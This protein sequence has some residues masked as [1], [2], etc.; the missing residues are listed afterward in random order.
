M[1]GGECV[2]SD[3][4]RKKEGGGMVDQIF[5]REAI[6]LSPPG[7]DRLRELCRFILTSHNQALH[8]LQNHAAYEEALP[9]LGQT[10]KLCRQFLAEVSTL[11][12]INEE[13]VGSWMEEC[14]VRTY[15]SCPGEETERKIMSYD[16]EEPPFLLHFFVELPTSQILASPMNSGT[17]VNMTIIVTWNWALAHHLMGILMLNPPLTTHSSNPGCLHPPSFYFQK[18]TICYQLAYRMLQT[19]PSTRTVT[20][21]WSQALLNNLALVRTQLGD[22]DGADATWEC[23]WRT[24]RAYSE[25]DDNHSSSHAGS[26]WLSS[27]IWRNVRLWILASRS[28]GPAPAA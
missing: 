2:R 18:A 4:S 27:Q 22:L 26:R 8:F 24:H 9:L 6:E 7:G 3:V 19:L 15:Y 1:T 20:S 11:T 28:P 10:V 16:N 25:S 23:L 17:A 5:S 21:S 13:D 14:L 12:D